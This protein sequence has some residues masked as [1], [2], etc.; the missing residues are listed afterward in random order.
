MHIINSAAM[1][2]WILKE[3]NKT[4]EENDD[5]TKSKKCLTIDSNRM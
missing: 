5:Y 3:N 1:N 4:D 2:N